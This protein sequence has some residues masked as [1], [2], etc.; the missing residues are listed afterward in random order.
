MTIKPII[1]EWSHQPITID[2]ATSLPINVSVQAVGAAGVK[3]DPGNAADHGALTG[4]ADDDHAQYHNDSRGDARYYTKAQ[5]DS[6]LAGK[7]SLIHGHAIA[8]VTGLQTALDGKQEALGFT[9]ENTANRNAING[10]A[11]LDGSGKVAAAQLPSFVDDVVEA[12]NFAALP[13]TGE[14]GKIYVTLDTNK[15]YRWGGSAYAEISASP[16]ST[17]A[18]PEGVTNLYHTA[19]RVNALISSSVGSVTQAW[20]ATLD[21]L[22]A[23]AT[24][25][26]GRSLLT[27]ASAAA[28][29]TQIGLTNATTTGR[30]ARYTDTAGGQGQT[31]G[32]YE[33]G[34]GNVAVGNTGP[35]VKFHVTGDSRLD[36]NVAMGGTAIN[37]ANAVS[38]ANNVTDPTIT[39]T[40]LS[41]SRTLVLTANNAFG[42]TGVSGT[43]SVSAN[44]FNPTGSLKGVFGQS[45]HSGTGAA[46]DTRG[47]DGL[48]YNTSTGTISAGAALRG[49]IQN[50][51]AAGK[52]T[53]AYG[54]HVSV[55]F[56]NGASGS[57]GDIT[58]TYGYYV[59]DITS[60]Q[61]TNQAYAFYNSDT[62]AR[63]YFGGKTGF[64]TVTAPATEIDCSGP[65]RARTYTV[66]TLPAAATV[67]AGAHTYVT[68]AN[69]T[70]AAGI[71]TTV[72]GG[73]A[74]FVRVT[75]NGTNWIIM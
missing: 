58:N 7:A 59:A 25:V 37:T 31:A 1:I 62:N 2:L 5:S 50:L 17:D 56:N 26:F 46:S 19:S 54:C 47:V 52:I 43:V 55:A 30:L 35:A 44:A 12:A 15:T 75:S 61:Q 13:G 24:T 38:I 65:I 42:I 73:G 9:P 20:S 72:A 53:N 8:D 36:G 66:A 39:L 57:G 29:R 23:V 67:G 40:G 51:N 27:L 41:A 16:G 49:T 34:S 45:S 74:N 21:A 64:G 71:G 18:V 32:L 68:D 14:T 63:S 22:A 48:I 4:L 28:L 69:T 11:G 60:G 33:D 10:Y 6:A 70:Y 3:G